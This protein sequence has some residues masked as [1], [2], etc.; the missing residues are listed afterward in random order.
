MVDEEIS[1]EFKTVTVSFRVF[2]GLMVLISQPIRLI[3][4]RSCAEN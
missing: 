1:N 4:T 2:K 3:E